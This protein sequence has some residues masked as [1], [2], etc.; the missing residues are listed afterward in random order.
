MLPI[1]RT[2]KFWP[3]FTDDLFNRD[4]MSDFVDERPRVN[5]PAVNIAESK[6]EFRIEVAAPGLQKD[7]FKI[8]LEHNVL[9]VSCEKECRSEEQEDK[10][11]RKEF[12]YA[13]F[14]R[15]FTLPNTVETEKIKA[16]HKDGI[17][18]VHIPKREEAK[19]KP[20]KQIEIQ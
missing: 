19:V 6:D 12:C 14:S 1:L 18:A 11:V 17:L 10:Y 16:T 9:T 3:S 2:A 20:P 15:S 5:I 13:S 7:D 4:F 8:N